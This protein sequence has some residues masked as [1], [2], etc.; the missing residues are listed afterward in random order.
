MRRAAS[1][2]L[3]PLR[4]YLLVT[5]MDVLASS[6][7]MLTEDGVRTVE[8][9][10]ISGVRTSA[11]MSSSAGARIKKEWIDPAS[12]YCGYP[13]PVAKWNLLD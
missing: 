8:N 13:L 7:G 11:R 6:C 3:S 12:W 1:R 10:D 2:L 4:L 9:R 5:R